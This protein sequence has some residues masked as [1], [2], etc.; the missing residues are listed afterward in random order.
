MAWRLQTACLNLDS[1]LRLSAGSGAGALEQQLRDKVQEMLQLQSR[2]DAE[3]V[4]LQARWVPGSWTC[5]PSAHVRG[6]A[7]GGR[8]MVPKVVGSQ[9]PSQPPEAEL[10]R[11][12]VEG[13]RGRCSGR[14][15]T[16]SS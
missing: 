15:W 16:A 12:N 6:G 5:Q 1:N 11:P 7:P 10:E 8:G 2:W 9:V 14:I 3:K 4:A 13:F